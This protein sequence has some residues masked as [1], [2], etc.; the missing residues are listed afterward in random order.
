MTISNFPPSPSRSDPAN[1][2]DEADAF[3]GHFPTFVTEVNALSADVDAK[4]LA[5]ASSAS[6][7][8]TSATT[9]SNAAAQAIAS[10]NFKGSWSSLTGPLNVPASVFHN[11]A[12]WMLLSNLAD[13]TTATPGV[14]AVWQVIDYVTQ[15]ISAGGTGATTGRGAITLLRQNAH[16]HVNASGVTFQAGGNYGVWTGGGSITATMPSYA[17]TEKGDVIE[18]L[19]LQR[20]WSSTNTCTITFPSQ[21]QYGNSFFGNGDTTLVLNTSTVQVVTLTCTWK[22]GTAAWW[23][24]SLGLG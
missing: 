10:S 20:T 16:Q 9:A 12:W 21:T 19:N 8:S 5:A 7:A 22:D 14:S 1:F 17:N 23:G 6:T 11:N 2:S 24:L 4:Q 3:L 15:P 13:V 18:L